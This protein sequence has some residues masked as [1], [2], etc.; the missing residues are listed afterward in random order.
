MSLVALGWFGQASLGH[1][2]VVCAFHFTTIPLHRRREGGLPD[3]DALFRQVLRQTSR[4][5]CRG[6][7]KAAERPAHGALS[8]AQQ[9]VVVVVSIR[10][11]A[12]EWKGSCICVA[13][14][15]ISQNVHGVDSYGFLAPGKGT[16]CVTDNRVGARPL[17]SR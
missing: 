17:C 3:E 13:Q 4:R 1:G 9:T 10:Q 15:S 12:P 5:W 8:V 16:M 2:F 7:R 14:S 6:G 11:P